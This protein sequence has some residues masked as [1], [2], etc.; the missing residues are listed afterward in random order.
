MGDTW[1][2]VTVRNVAKHVAAKW[3][4]WRH[5]WEQFRPVAHPR[6]GCSDC[7]YFGG[8]EHHPACPVVNRW[9]TAWYARRGLTEPVPG[10]PE[11]LVLEALAAGV[12]P[13]HWWEVRHG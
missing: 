6:Q 2:H 8:D 12:P 4:L 13:L 7:G 11:L 3:W 5:R 9:A 10:T 1:K